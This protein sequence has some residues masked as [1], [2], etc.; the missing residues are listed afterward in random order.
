MKN[1]FLLNPYKSDSK[2]TNN[3]VEIVAFKKF[4]L[5]VWRNISSQKTFRVQ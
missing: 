4:Q 1:Y 5:K 3:I 2:Y